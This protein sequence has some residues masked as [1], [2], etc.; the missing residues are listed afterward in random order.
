[1][2]RVRLQGRIGNQL[3]QYAFALYASQKL[4]TNFIVDVRQKDGYQLGYFN[5]PPPL[6]YLS[7]GI[8]A[9][10]LYNFIHRNYKMKKTFFMG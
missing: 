5:L 6:K 7:F 2:I 4:K 9:Q 10:L 3:F 1:M 8:S